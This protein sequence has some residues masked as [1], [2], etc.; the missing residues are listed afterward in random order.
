MA[1][2]QSANEYLLLKDYETRDIL[3][4]LTLRVQRGLPR[5][6]S[7]L[8]WLFPDGISALA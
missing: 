6:T 8:S 7:W 5:I 2:S 3:P 4:T 1:K